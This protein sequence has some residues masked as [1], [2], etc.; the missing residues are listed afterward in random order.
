MDYLEDLEK[1]EVFIDVTNHKIDLEYQAARDSG[2]LRALLARDSFELRA[3]I[4]I[5]RMVTT[6]ERRLS[7]FENQIMATQGKM[8]IF[9]RQ[10][11]AMVVS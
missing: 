2:G 6:L 4:E 9:Y 10:N 3:R 7:N 5:K 11:H 8:G 1:L